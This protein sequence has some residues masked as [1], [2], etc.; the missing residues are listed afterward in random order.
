[1][2]Y[3]KYTNPYKAATFHFTECG[4]LTGVWLYSQGQHFKFR[5]FFV[6]EKTYLQIEG[7]RPRLSPYGQ[8]S[9]RWHVSYTARTFGAKNKSQSEPQCQQ[10]CSEE[11]DVR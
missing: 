4:L 5:D 6:I 11:S 1:M 7:P 2:K 10:T 3:S 9:V 8:L